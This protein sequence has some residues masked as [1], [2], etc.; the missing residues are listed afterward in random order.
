[1]ASNGNSVANNN[2]TATNTYSN[3]K[4]H[5]PQSSGVVGIRNLGSTDFINVV[6]QCLAHTPWL[7]KE[8][9]LN[10]GYI[11]DLNSSNPLGWNGKLGKEYSKFLFQLF[12][13]QL[14]TLTIN[15]FHNFLRQIVPKFYGDQRL[16]RNSSDFLRFLLDGLHEDLNQ[17]IQKPLTNT[18]QGNYDNLNK[19]ELTQIANNHWDIVLLEN[20]S[21]FTDLLWGQILVR[22]QCPHCDK[23]ASQ[24]EHYYTL[25]LKLPKEKNFNVELIW[26]DQTQNQIKIN[27]TNGNEPILLSIKVDEHDNLG[28]L[29]HEIYK[30]LQIESENDES[31]ENVDDINSINKEIVF[32]TANIQSRTIFLE[33]KHGDSDL[34]GNVCN[35]NKTSGKLFGYYVQL[36]KTRNEIRYFNIK[37]KDCNKWIGYPLIV[38]FDVGIKPGI[39]INQV[40]NHVKNVVRNSIKIQ[41]QKKNMNMNNVNINVDINNIEIEVIWGY[42]NQA[43]LGSSDDIF[44]LIINERRLEFVISLNWKDKQENCIIKSL[45]TPDEI[46]SLKPITGNVGNN[47]NNNSHVTSI[48][49]CIENYLKEQ[50]LGRGKLWYCNKCQELKYA[51][52]KKIFWNLPNILIIDLKRITH[53]PNGS[54]N[55]LVDVQFAING[56]Y[57]QVLFSCYQILG[58]YVDYYIVLQVVSLLM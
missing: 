20:K 51:K 3:N 13:D 4:I 55:N 30:R 41:K 47:N 42:G 46:Q 12:S 19:N 54:H 24:F 37:F 15:H 52:C 32:Y 1:M 45:S 29:K 23:I 49:E 28:T 36:P 6:L 44:D 8:Y 48:E 33:N 38:A 58:L 53:S 18:P 27:Q 40:I 10:G 39:T 25:P 35:K 7:T 56:C 26:I 9:F 43:I 2:T 50:V 34:V 22:F 5:H 16:Y 57:L 11:H 14:T 17:I 21:V 31:K